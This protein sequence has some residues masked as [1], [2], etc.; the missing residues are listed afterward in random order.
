VK[1]RLNAA[2]VQLTSTQDVAANLRRANALINKAADAGADLVMLPENYGF[3]G[4][5]VDKLAHAQDADDGPFITPLRD[6]A[7]Q[8]GLWILAGS[9]PERGP[10]TKHTY[11]TSVLIN[12][13]GA[14][15]A[16]Y[17]K[18][19][20][21]DV[22]L[23]DGSRLMESASVAPGDTPV[24]A[25]VEGWRVGLSVC[26]DLRFPELYRVLS[27]DGA[28]LL[29]IPAA[30]TRHTGKDHWEI[31][32]R[33][34]AIENLCF[35]AAAAQFG[36]HGGGRFSWGKSQIIDPWGVVLAGT[37]E[38]EGFALATLDPAVQNNARAQ[39]PCL[40]HRR[41]GVVGT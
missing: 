3:L 23:A 11:N 41:L 35:V 36:S 29:A 17:R 10:D 1:N 5:D 27:D 28:E 12:R 16:R 22:D 21:F 26:Y 7:L 9:L 15:A 38:G 33:A 20:L 34:R 18:I 37:S 24:V 6:L 14:V 8:R 13:Q 2:V 4:R 40:G 31:L 32:L 39:I 19:H 25:D 30:F